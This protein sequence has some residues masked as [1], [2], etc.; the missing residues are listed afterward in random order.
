M[1]YLNWI[2]QNESIVFV[3]FNMITIFLV[4][5]GWFAVFVF[6]LRKDKKLM[7]NKVQMKIYEELYEL[8]KDVDEKSIDL[9]MLLSLYSL[10]FLKMKSV[11]M[12]KSL[13]RFQRNIEALKIWSEYV[14]KI[15]KETSEFDKYYLKLWN[16]VDMWIGAMPELKRAKKEL[17]EIQ[18]K[19]LTDDLWDYQRY[20]MELS[21]R[22]HHWNEWN[23]KEIEEKAKKIEMEFHQIGSAYLDGFMV[24]VHNCLVSSILGYKKK[25][26]ENF[27]KIPDKI[28]TKDGVEETKKK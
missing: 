22:K 23:K 4:V 10:P 2:S 8:R 11:D 26:L 17:F 27:N 24:E 19:K 6:G 18:F 20:L 28:L 13:D 21:I 14:E 9:G 25:P 7:K 16:H 15:A 12:N 3:V 1:D 5:F